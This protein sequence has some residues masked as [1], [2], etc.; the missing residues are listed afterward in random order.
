[1]WEQTNVTSSPS[2]VQAYFA[3]TSIHA[4]G[5]LTADAVA[6]Q[7][8]QAIV[9]AG[10]VGIGGGGEAGIAVS[11]AGVYT[12]NRI[13]THIKAF[14]DGDGASGIDAASLSL[15]A[16]DIS[17]IT[18]S[19]GAASIAAGLGGEIG[20]GISIGIS[21]AINEI[22]NQVASYIANANN[23]VK[24]T[25]GGITISASESATIDALSLAASLAVGLGGEAGVA[26]SG[27]GAWPA[28]RFSPTPRHTSQT[29]KSK[30]RLLSISRRAIPHPSTPHFG[31]FG[32][33]GG[34]R[35]SGRGASIGISI[36]QNTIGDTSNPAE[37]LAYTQNSTVNA[38]DG[39][40]TIHA[41]GNEIIKALVI[42]ASAA[43]A[44]GGTVGV[45]FSGSG[46]YASNVIVDFVKAFIDDDDNNANGTVKGIHANSISIVA[47]ETSVI[48]AT[49]AAASLAASF[50]GTAGGFAVDRRFAGAQR[51]S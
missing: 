3:D 14:I 19:A 50:A 16:S 34:R 51:D 36:A 22:N 7:N 46:V 10:S 20:V 43:I 21:L 39:A 11:G 38:K 17:T 40:L 13:E 27:A 4:A 28:T 12:E 41:T 30:A 6:D 24:T 42:A 47:A 35:H 9:F 45:G 32:G 26:I 5:A 2:E 37:V 31:G 1:L 29:A 15:L 25:T 48:V 8:I 44:G 18:A 33:R 23:Q 49:A